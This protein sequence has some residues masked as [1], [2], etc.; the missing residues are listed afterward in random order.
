[1]EQRKSQEIVD[2][3]VKGYRLRGTSLLIILKMKWLFWD[4]RYFHVE[5]RLRF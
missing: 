2:N 5:K 3:L 4:Q 1:M